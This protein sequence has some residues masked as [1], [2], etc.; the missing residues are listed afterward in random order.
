MNTNLEQRA[1][2]LFYDA[3]DRPRDEREAFLK[4]ACLDDSG[5][6]AEVDELLRAHEEA[7]G[8]LKADVPVSADL[9]AEFA[10]L[11]PEEAGDRIGN[12]KLLQQIGEGGFGVVWMAEQE[13]PVR[14]R[15]A[16][17]IIKLG[18]DTREVIARFEQERQAL[19]MMD[20]PNIAK[21]LDAGATPTGRPFFVMELVRGI[22]ITEYCDQSKLPTAE[23]L[24]LFIAVC[25]AVQHAHQKGI[26]HRDLKPSNILVTQ[27][28]GVPVPKVIDFGVAKAT[29]QQRLTDLTLFTQFE[30]MIGTPLYMSPEQAEMSGLDIDTRSD[31]YSLGVLLYELLVGRTPFDPEALMKKGLD[32]IRRTIREQEPQKPSTF[33]STMALDLRTSIAQQRQADGARLI[34]QIRG[35]LDWIVMKALE[36]DRNR[37]YETPSGLAKDIERH[38]LSEPV[39]ARPPARLY[40]FRR[41]AKRNKIAFAAAGI[42]LVA[43]V[44]GLGTST[45]MYFQEKA[46]RLRAVA[47]EE[48][49]GRLRQI[50]LAAEKAQE[51]QRKT[52]ELEAAKS[53]QV[54]QFLTG[55]L[56]EVGPSV[57]LG[58]DT[59]IIAEILDATAG[60]ISEGLKDQPEVEAELRSIIGNV[61]LQIGDLAKASQMHN[62]AL[63]LWKNC[64]GDEHLR[65]ADSLND[66]G[67]TLDQQGNLDEAEGLYRQALAMRRKLLGNVHADVARSLIHLAGV[68][69]VQGKLAEAETMHREALAIRRSLFGDE[70]RDVLTSLCALYILVREQGRQ[71]ESEVFEHEA[72]ELTGRIMGDNSSKVAGEL[73]DK[74]MALRGQGKYEEAEAMLYEPLAKS[75]KLLGDEHPDTL[76]LLNTIAVVRAETGNPREG[77]PMLREVITTTRKLFGNTDR[78]L[79]TLISNLAYNLK[80]Q[81]RYSE[82]EALFRQ[83]LEMMRSH[84][85]NA[86]LVHAV[87]GLATVLSDQGKLADAEAL[88]REA[89]ELGRS[90]AV[91]EPGQLEELIHD[92]A[93]NLYRQAKYAEAEPLYRELIEK[94]ESRTGI[95]RTDHR[96]SL[97]RLLSDWAWTERGNISNS[98]SQS[99]K[100]RKRTQEAEKLLREGL[101]ARLRVGQVGKIADARSRLGAALV[102]VVVTDPTLTGASRQAKLVE[103]EQLL[104]EGQKGLQAASTFGDRYWRDAQAR[105]INLYTAWNKPDKVAEWQQRL[106]DFDQAAEEKRKTQTG[107][108]PSPE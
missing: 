86:D 37:R 19:A 73:L 103:A 97:A 66:L 82:S 25:N 29:Q 41:F 93:D 71:A 99:L 79:P 83:A 92:L 48:E 69:R 12:Y 59:K 43:L 45:W 104:L 17:K 34:G 84:S 75:R 32:E 10:R 46:A 101:A 27:H 63:A 72:D 74:V 15:V 50:A 8:F 28:D 22:K 2:R 9:Q 1:E 39:Q 89:L 106:A 40:R 70:H 52:A 76:Y 62:Q 23:R 102:A 7:E 61:Y 65:V 67:A 21:V 44:V 33:V 100:M 105:L 47:A 80:H 16:L 78:S 38:M 24:T 13:R 88:R 54:A 6:R 108:A 51:Q 5:L 49:Q 96:A 107:G 68:Q 20:H 55:M 4:A 35:D 36:K 94:R 26:I 58:R 42:V 14:R 95:V 90:T 53:S 91:D 57:A 31:I 18:M 98:S 3:L 30:Q 77:E 81:R 11:K 64:F 85:E 87:H 56:K 60:R